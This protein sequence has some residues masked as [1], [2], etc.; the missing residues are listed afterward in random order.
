MIEDLITVHISSLFNCFYIVRKDTDEVLLE[1]GLKDM[2]ISMCSCYL[3]G[4]Q[5]GLAVLAADEYS[6]ILEALLNIKK[7]P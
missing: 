1:I 6:T 2:P 7:T 4:D 5:E 3:N